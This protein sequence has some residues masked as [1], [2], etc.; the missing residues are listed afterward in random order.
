MK[1]A[2][3]V[4]SDD[5]IFIYRKGNGGAFVSKSPAVVPSGGTFWMVNLTECKAEVTFPDKIVDP[6]EATLK[7]NGAAQRFT[8]SGPKGYYEYDVELNCDR[9]TTQHVEANSRPG[10]IIDG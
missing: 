9:Q 1:T 10:V 6:A 8:V 7:A 3:R 2:K 5:S 4:N